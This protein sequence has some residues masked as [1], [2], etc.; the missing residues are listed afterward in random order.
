M[1]AQLL[2]TTLPAQ[3]ASLDRRLADVVTVLTDIRTALAPAPVQPESQTR[4]ASVATFD[5]DPVFVTPES[6]VVTVLIARCA[7][8][9]LHAISIGTAV[10]FRFYAN[11]ND[12]VAVIPSADTGMILP[13]GV[14]ISVTTNP[15]AVIMDLWYQSMDVPIA[16]SPSGANA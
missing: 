12:A 1:V 11:V 16:Q 6:A 2:P 5:P 15:G 9:G 13:R 14:P 7:A 4:H 3:L 10:E 8:A